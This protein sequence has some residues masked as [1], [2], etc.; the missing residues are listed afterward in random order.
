[1]AIR[2]MKGKLAVEK[3]ES[4]SSS[5]SD[6]GSYFKIPET[7][8]NFGTIRFIAPELADDQ[9]FEGAQVYYGERVEPIRMQG[10]NVL[11]MTVENVIATVADEQS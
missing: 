9:L 11:I 3:T 2:M 4:K 5:E 10:L 1:M 6:K 8:H 7:L